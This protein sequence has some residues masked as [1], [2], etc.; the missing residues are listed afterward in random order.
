MYCLMVN[1][2]KGLIGCWTMDGVDLIEGVMKDRS[3]FDQHGV[4]NGNITKG[5]ESPLGEACEFD[6]ENGSID[7]ENNSWAT[8]QISI[9]MWAKKHVDSGTENDYAIFSTDGEDN[10]LL[11]QFTSDRLR[12]WGRTSPESGTRRDI[13]FKVGKW[14]HI[15]VVY[16]YGDETVYFYVDGEEYPTDGDQFGMCGRETL[17][18]GERTGNSRTFDGQISDVRVYNRTLSQKEIKILYNMRNRRVRKS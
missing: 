9:V 7:M 1:L 18:I 10:D 6:G 5:H 8:E 13:D 2:Q 15:A 14:Y 3:G 17:H 16:E 12:F 11:F 4:I